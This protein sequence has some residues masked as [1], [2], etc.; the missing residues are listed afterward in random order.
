MSGFWL[1]FLDELRHLR[2]V[3]FLV[4]ITVLVILILVA[5]VLFNAGSEEKIPFDFVFVQLSFMANLAVGSVLTSTLINDINNKTL[6]PI[7]ARP[8]TSFSILFSRTAALVIS[9]FAVMLFALLIIKIASHIFNFNIVAAIEF[10]LLYLYSTFF[11]QLISTVC[12]GLIIGIFVTAPATGQVAFV[13]ICIPML[14]LLY[15]AGS[16]I[17]HMLGLNLALFLMIITSLLIM[18]IALTILSRYLKIQVIK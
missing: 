1:L 4:W 9:V 17:T 5:V 7:L 16:P 2:R 15:M 10:S 3:R 8:V 18:F 11:V 14:V 12:L 6:L 13:F